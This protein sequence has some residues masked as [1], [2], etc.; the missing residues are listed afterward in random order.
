MGVIFVFYFERKSCSKNI[1]AYDGEISEQFK[2][3]YNEDF[4]FGLYSHQTL[5][6]KC[7]TGGHNGL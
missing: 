3:L 5:L 2:T 6:E 4:F 1:W 7:S